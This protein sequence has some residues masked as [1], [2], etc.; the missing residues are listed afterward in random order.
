LLQ[1]YVLNKVKKPG[2]SDD[3]PQQKPSLFQI[4]AANATYI[5]QKQRGGRNVID[6]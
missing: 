3:A 5:A 6:S 1:H 2:L 4:R